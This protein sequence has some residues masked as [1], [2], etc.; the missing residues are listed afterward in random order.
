[1]MVLIHFLHS[2]HKEERNFSLHGIQSIFHQ[3]I[4]QSNSAKIVDFL[5]IV[6]PGPTD[7]PSLVFCVASFPLS[8]S[9]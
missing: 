6:L 8:F 3:S 7:L 5:E 9:I 4:C 2:L 1:M